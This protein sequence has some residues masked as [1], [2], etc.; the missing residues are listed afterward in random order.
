VS[1]WLT[2]AVVFGIYLG[3]ALGIV[4]LVTEWAS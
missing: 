4:L 2:F 1:A 3:V